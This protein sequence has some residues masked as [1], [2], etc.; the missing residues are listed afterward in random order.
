M[1]AVERDLANVLLE[2]KTL[3]WYH[4]L[5]IFRNTELVD[6]L[7]L[8]NLVTNAVQTVYS[9]VQRKESRGA[10]AREDYK[11]RDDTNWLKHT[12]SFQNAPTSK[13]SIEFRPVQLKTLDESEC[14]S[15][16]PMKRSY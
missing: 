9:A 1:Q 2:D 3:I 6:F 11:E 10:H 5:S 14:S 7:E 15:V 4:M 16:K 12:L 8:R 13:V